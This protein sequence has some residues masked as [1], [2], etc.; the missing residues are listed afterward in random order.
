MTEQQ[1]PEIKLEVRKNL[2]KLLPYIWKDKY[3]FLCGLVAMLFTSCMRLID[4]LILAHIIDYSVPHHDVKDM[5]IYA[6]YFVG[7]IGL[8]GL[9]SYIQ[10]ILLS[11]LGIKIITEFKGHIFDHLLKLP[12]SYFDKNAVGEIIARVES[13]SERVRML[14]TDLSVAILGNIIF[15]IGIFSVL[16]WKQ[17]KITSQLIL[18]LIVM[19]IAYSFVIRYLNKFY[20]RSRVLNA[21]ITA[22]LTEFLQGM[23]I[24]QLF[25][26]Q[27]RVIGDLFVSSNEKKNVDIKASFVEYGFQGIFFFVFNILFVIMIIIL[28]APKII[29]HVMTIGT[30]IVF[31]Q[32]IA[33]VIWPLMNISENITNI[34]R[35]FVSLQRIF[36]ITELST[37]YETLLGEEEPVFDHSIEFRNVWFAYDD[38]EWV[39]QDVSF[40]IPKGGKIALVGASGSGKTTTI[41]L[42]CGFYRIQK[43]EILIDGKNLYQLDMRKWRQKLGLILQDIYLFPGNILEN[44]RIYNDEIDQLKVD[45]SI[46]LVQ[47]Q[48]FVNNLPNGLYSEL[49]ERG[50]NISQGEKQLISFA[51]A[52]CFDPEVVIMDEATASIDQLTESRI[53]QSL[54][55]M[56]TDKTAVIVAHRLASILDS[57]QILMFHEGQIIHRGTHNELLKTA[58]EYQKLVELQFLSAKEE[59]CE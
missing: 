13:D 39:L 20:K 30:L 22:K 55:Q 2:K 48:E 54:H 17:W 31:T 18:P 38:E 53:Q 29:A 41:S 32:Y 11:R 16:L 50:Q 51:R 4:P 19:I 35:A 45:Q 7:V 21:D 9:L 52:I 28:T 14:F 49:S 23:P 37:E 46:R 36:S 56:L 12:I 40:L 42:L 5:F 33:R 58:R 34:Q 44:V 47:A 24:V 43:G 10:I 15:F 3:L 1:K 27:K 8:S 26:Q 25:N 57:D 6:G 59:A